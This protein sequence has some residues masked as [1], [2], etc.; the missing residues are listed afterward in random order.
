[1]GGLGVSHQRRSRHFLWLLPCPQS[2][3]PGPDRRLE[4]RV[5]GAQQ[6]LV[7]TH[8][9]GEVFRQKLMQICIGRTLVATLERRETP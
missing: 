9:F 7:I 6:S 4:L 8:I 3:E 2:I 1:M 5:A